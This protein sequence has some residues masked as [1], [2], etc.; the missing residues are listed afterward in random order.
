MAEEE[1]GKE[2]TQLHVTIEEARNI[3]SL[4]RY[5]V[6]LNTT[7]GLVSPTERRLAP[8]TYRAAELAALV[9]E[10]KTLEEAA[11]EAETAWTGSLEENYRRALDIVRSNRESLQSAMAELLSPEQLADYLEIS[12]QQV[13]ELV[14]S[15]M[16]N[17]V[18]TPKE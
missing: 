5:V 18:K 11:R 14:K 6:S 7:V 12:Q 13:L 4:L 2:H 9:F 3:A 10:G 8:P 16:L 15:G 17:P 1:A